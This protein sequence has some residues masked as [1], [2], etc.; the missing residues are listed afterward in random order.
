[1]YSKLFVTEA[2]I[3]LIYIQKSKVNRKV[4]LSVCLNVSVTFNSTFIILTIFLDSPGLKI[5]TDLL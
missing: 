2:S 4:K 1:M 3:V 5:P